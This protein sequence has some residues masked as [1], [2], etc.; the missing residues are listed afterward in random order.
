MRC[1]TCQRELSLELFAFKNMRRGL[2]HTQCRECHVDYVRSHRALNP[3]KYN[4]SAIHSRKQKLLR[5]KTLIENKLRAHHCSNPSCQGT[6]KY[7]CP[8]PM[9]TIHR[10]RSLSEIEHLILKATVICKYCSPNNEK[11]QDIT[12]TRIAP[13]MGSTD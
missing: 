13:R 4:E 1:R 11:I 7:L 8:S 5:A 2:R 12:N 9:K 10:N 3:D 6:E